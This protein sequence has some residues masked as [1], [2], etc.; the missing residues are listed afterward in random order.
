MSD[1]ESH[2]LHLKQSRLSDKDQG[3]I[4]SLEDWVAHAEFDN[5]NRCK[6][7]LQKWNLLCSMDLVS[8]LP[9][10][11]F[12]I[13]RIPPF[14]PLLTLDPKGERPPTETEPDAMIVIRVIGGSPT[15]TGQKGNKSHTIPLNVRHAIWFTEGVQ[16]TP[17]VD[18]L[19]MTSKAASAG[20]QA[21]A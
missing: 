7:E 6:I 3:I 18:M 10:P 9:F 17:A 14:H 2:T 13:K 5:T 16:L 12:Q 15:V 20:H 1:S 19:L 8:K 21:A 11:T 4:R